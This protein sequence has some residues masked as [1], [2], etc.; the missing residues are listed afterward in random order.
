MLPQ[1]AMADSLNA[2]SSAGGGESPA[3]AAA[4]PAAPQLPPLNVTVKISDKGFDAQAYDAS[5]IPWPSPNNGT[6]TFKN[7]GTQVHTATFMPGTQGYGVRILS[8][9]D[10]KGGI[11][12]CYS[13]PTL[14]AM[15][16]DTCGRT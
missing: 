10:Q 7:V 13:N 5:T 16:T 9:T 1:A 11:S 12:T 8:V 3:P 2:L 14:F 15:F 6:V 4:A